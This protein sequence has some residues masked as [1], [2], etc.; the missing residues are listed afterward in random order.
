M[1]K[2]PDHGRVSEIWRG[3]KITDRNQ[4]KVLRAL[5]AY[6]DGHYGFGFVSFK[7]ICRRTKLSRPVVRRICRHLARKGMAEYAKGMFNLDGEVAGAG[8]AITQAGHVA[9]QILA[10]ERQ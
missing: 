6:Y 2:N 10:G 9:L 5:D 4:L 3:L 7:P 8:Y 1:L